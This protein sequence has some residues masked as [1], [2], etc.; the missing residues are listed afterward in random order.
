MG[1]QVLRD[2]R[3]RSSLHPLIGKFIPEKFERLDLSGIPPI[4]LNECRIRTRHRPNEILRRCG[5][6]LAEKGQSNTV[7]TRKIEKFFPIIVQNKLIKKEAVGIPASNI[8]EKRIT[9]LI[10]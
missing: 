4:A 2:W 9:H 7:V 8:S 10:R 1:T 3:P 6:E 5:N